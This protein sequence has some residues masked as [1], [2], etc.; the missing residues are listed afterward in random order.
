M[1]SRR[2]PVLLYAE[3]D[4]DGWEQRKGDEYRDGRLDRA[5]H[6]GG[7]GTTLLA[8]HRIAE[9]AE[10]NTHAEFEPRTFG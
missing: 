6:D 9:V 7:S 10:I 2:E 8:D 5:D 1:R 4:D 3:I